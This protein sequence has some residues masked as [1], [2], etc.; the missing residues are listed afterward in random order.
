MSLE[1][2]GAADRLIVN[3]ASFLVGL[4]ALTFTC[5][6]RCNATLPY[7]LG[8]FK[9]NDQWGSDN[10]IGIRYDASGLNGGGTQ[11][12][13]CG[14]TINGNE[15]QTETSDFSQTNEWQFVV[16]TWESGTEI[17]IYLDGQKD[18]PTSA[19]G[20]HSGTTGP[21]NVDLIFFG[22]GAKAS[23]TT[24]WNG[25]MEDVRFYDRRLT[26]SEIQTMF[27]VKGNDN[28]SQNLLFRV[29][30]NELPI[31]STATT[32]SIIDL[33]G[34]LAIDDVDGTPTYI[35]SPGFSSRRSTRN[36]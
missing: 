21:D 27:H 16:M 36:N 34:N 14:I 6:I 24:G 23:S 35:E 18:T 10:G 31:G 28:I 4:T 1:F 17:D 25:L 2:T 33:S 15:E 12:L 9:T 13:K 11:V 20:V 7:D 32:N 30:F 8:F 5:W 19:S 22:T 29:L 26:D 3:D